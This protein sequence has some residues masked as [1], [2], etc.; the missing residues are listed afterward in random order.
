MTAGKG[1]KQL[2]PLLCSPAGQ[3][4]DRSEKRDALGLRRTHRERVR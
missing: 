2:R 1:E 3:L 4:A